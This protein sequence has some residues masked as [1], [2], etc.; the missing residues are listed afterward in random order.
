MPQTLLLPCPGPTRA[1]APGRLIWLAIAA[2]SLAMLPACQSATSPEQ[3]NKALESVNDVDNTNIAEVMLTLG[4]P[5]EAVAYFTQ[6][7]AANPENLTAQRGL[8]KSLVKAGR[9]K[10]A[11]A[12]WQRIIARPDATHDDRISYAEAL[13]RGNDWDQAAQVL[14]QIP[15]TY[16]T[17]DRYR[18]EA[19]VA[20]SQK[21]WKK[22]DSFYEIAAG[23]SQQPAPILNN[24]GFSKLT[25]GDAPGAE[26][27]FLQSLGYDSTSFT[28][29]NNLVLARAM[30]RKY[31]LPVIES[32]QVERAQLYYTAGLAAI[33]QGDPNV[34]KELLRTAIET[35]P[36]YFEAAERSLAA[37]GG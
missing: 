20:D 26:Q 18:L 9:P 17:M 29:K 8:G 15:P 1:S 4:K 25:R 37:L 33:K 22:A 16:E 5:E 36:Q 35:H 2:L 27:L 24:W 6:V 10:D 19:M 34:G 13:I 12:V 32:S 21:N 11:M 23:M 7:L 31:D 28:V 14:A 30:Q 3:V